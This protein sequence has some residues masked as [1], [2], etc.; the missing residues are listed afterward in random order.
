MEMIPSVTYLTTNEVVPWEVTKKRACIHLPNISSKSHLPMSH[1]PWQSTPQRPMNLDILVGD[2]SISFTGPMPSFGIH[3]FFLQLVRNSSVLPTLT[4]EFGKVGK[5][6]NAAKVDHY[7]LFISSNSICLCNVHLPSTRL[8]LW[9]HLFGVCLIDAFSVVV[10]F[11]CI[12]PLCE[13]HPISS[14]DDITNTIANSNDYDDLFRD[15][16]SVWSFFF[17]G[18]K[19]IRAY[20][21]WHRCPFCIHEQI[22]V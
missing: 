13:M 14:P 22:S 2:G 5:T 20:F 4:E 6:E 7:F 18:P 21:L 17:F 3:C 11:H 1:I 15:S 19:K 8:P 16:S 10:S 9:C 12:F